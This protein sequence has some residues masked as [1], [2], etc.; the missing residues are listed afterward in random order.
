MAFVG[1]E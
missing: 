1:G